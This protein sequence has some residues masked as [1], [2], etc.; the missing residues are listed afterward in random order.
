[1][2]YTSPK[3][4][5]A[6]EDIASRISALNNGSQAIVVQADL[7]TVEAPDKI[8]SATTEAFGEHIDILVNNAAVL[9]PGSILDATANDYAATF[10]V[11]VRGPLLMTKAVVPHLRAPG[12]IINISSIAARTGFDGLAVYSASKGA[13]ESLTRGLAAELGAAGHTVNA[14]SSGPVKTDMLADVP[15]KLVQ[16]QLQRTP[17]EHRHGTVDDIAQVVGW[18]SDESSRWISGQTIAAGGGYQML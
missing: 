13:L 5:P 8:V 11:N 14:V 4:G 17:V 18:L 2:V 15:D 10:D 7:S 1:M 6:A 9:L 3:S 12:R 16:I